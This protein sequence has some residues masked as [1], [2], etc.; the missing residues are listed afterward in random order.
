[1][2][3]IEIGD[4]VEGMIRHLCGRIPDREWSGV[5]FYTVEGSFEEGLTVHCKDI[6][7]M[8]I[9]S[10]TYTEFYTSPDV[11]RYMVDHD[12]LDCHM[13]LVHSH[14]SMPTFFSSTDTST[15]QEEGS[16]RN[17]FVSLIVNNAGTYTAAITRHVYAEVKN[18][19]SYTYEM[20]GDGPVSGTEEGTERKECIEY[21]M[22]NVIKP[23]VVEDPLDTRINEILEN[24]RKAAA[25]AE[26]AKTWTSRE[27]NHDERRSWVYYADDTKEKAAEV[28]DEPKKEADSRQMNILWDEDEFNSRVSTFDEKSFILTLAR[29]LTSS[30][31]C[32]AF[33]IDLDSWIS[34][35]DEVYA[36]KFTSV[37]DYSEWLSP[38]LEYLMYHIP[39]LPD[40]IVDDAA[41][42][43]YADAIMKRI[44]KPKGP[45]TRELLTQLDYYGTSSII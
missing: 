1:M 27:V 3:N 35:Y 40:D 28:K 29:L 9:G 22:M 19:T 33:N 24:K 30:M 38:Y 14:Q 21:F 45:Y 31:T 5:L 26:V 36:K 39:G 15:L 17:N 6:C 20:F 37:V 23:D 32:N 2:Y 8:D 44:G 34:N 41:V 18:N 42:A 11:A 4:K 43:V 25:K 10:A 13:A 12:L 16:D 7:L